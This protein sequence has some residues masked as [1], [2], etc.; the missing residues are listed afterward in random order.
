MKTFVHYL[1]CLHIFLFALTACSPKNITPPTA[2]TVQLKWVNQAQFA[3]F[4]VAADKGYY[5]EENI[6]IKFSP[7][8]VG[9]DIIDE[10]TS[11]RAQFGIIG[12][13]KIILAREQ[14]KP[15]KAIATIYRRNPFVVVALPKSGIT[16]PADLIGRTINIGGTDGLIQFTAMMTKLKLDIHKVNITP[17]SYDLQPF[18]S[19]QIDATPAVAAG[20]LIGILQHYPDANLIWAEDYGIHFYADTLFTTDQMIADNPDLVL[21]FLQ[22]TLKGHLY[23]VENPDDAAQISLLYAIDPTYEVQYQMMLASLPLINTGEDHIG[24]MKPEIWS[25]MEE[26]LREQGLLTQ[27]LDVTQVYTM[28]FMNEIFPSR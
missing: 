13:E 25:G 20:S 27:P 26:T 17:Y 15:V 24:W 1:L 6:N 12:A 11:G 23:A 4:Y 5:K 28:Q 7:G 19:G 8:G 3:G 14:G 22:A 18:Y 9:I 21:R 16:R 10:V 2:V